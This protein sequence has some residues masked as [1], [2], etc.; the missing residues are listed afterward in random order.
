MQVDAYLDDHAIWLI[1]QL[2]DMYGERICPNRSTVHINAAISIKDR[3]SIATLSLLLGPSVTEVVIERHPDDEDLGWLCY[4]LA[5]VGPDM[6]ALIMG[7]PYNDSVMDY[8]HLKC[9]QLANLER[10]GFYNLLWNGWLLLVNVPTVRAV[11][12]TTNH[13]CIG[14]KKVAE[15][16]KSVNFLAVDRLMEFDI[17]FVDTINV[18][19]T[20]ASLKALSGFRILKISGAMIGLYAAGRLKSDTVENDDAMMGSLASA[21]PG[22]QKLSTWIGVEIPSRMTGDNLRALLHR[23]K[24]LERLKLLLDLSDYEVQMYSKS[25]LLIASSLAVRKLTQ[26]LFGIEPTKIRHVARDPAL[27][28]PNV[29][30]LESGQVH[31]GAEGKVDVSVEA[32]CQ[33]RSSVYF[34][35]IPRNQSRNDLS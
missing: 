17:N 8:S 10:V 11:S 15:L 18:S 12:I 5:R 24:A 34:V 25:L 27:C 3:V 1:W 20:I 9:T 32:K 21:D 30:Q 14:L 2:L 16:G 13:R 22:L 6:N 35:C 33:L 28:Y 4:Q 23:C 29:A 31:A 19:N 7:K 26:C